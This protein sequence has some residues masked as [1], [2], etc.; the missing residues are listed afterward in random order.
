[1]DYVPLLQ[2]I[3][4]L[5]VPLVEQRHLVLYVR[6]QIVAQL[7][8]LVDEVAAHLLAVTELQ[9]QLLHLGLTVAYLCIGF[10]QLASGLGI[11]FAQRLFHI[12][13]KQQ[14]LFVFLLDA[15]AGN[16]EF[17]LSVTQCESSPSTY[18]IFCSCSSPFCNASA[19]IRTTSS[20][21]CRS[22]S[23]R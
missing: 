19:S 2:L 22:R 14:I 15:T 16:E 20:S 5:L 7:V 9:L 1:M 18:S 17:N 4:F 21:S 6:V 11:F 8:A 3:H 23:A 10:G 13:G 12:L